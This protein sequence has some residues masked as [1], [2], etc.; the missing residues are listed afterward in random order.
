MYQS[1]RKMAA[2]LTVDPQFTCSQQI[3]FAYTCM[4]L[5]TL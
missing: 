3:I 1:S 2:E 5:W 4:L